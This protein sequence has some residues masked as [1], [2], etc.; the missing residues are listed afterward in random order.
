MRVGP[1]TLIGGVSLM[2]LYVAAFT[3]SPIGPIT[4]GLMAPA[5]LWRPIT[6]SVLFAAMPFFVDTFWIKELALFTVYMAPLLA[7]D[8]LVR[9]LATTRCR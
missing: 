2:V 5:Y 6:G 3:S 1:F 9:R 7:A 8:A 4:G